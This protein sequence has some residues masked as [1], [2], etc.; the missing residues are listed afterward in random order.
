MTVADIKTMLD[1]P[2]YAIIV[3]N[4]IKTHKVIKII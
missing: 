2:M 3:C 4:K 1:I